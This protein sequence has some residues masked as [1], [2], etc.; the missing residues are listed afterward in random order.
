MMIRR[1]EL[2]HIMDEMCKELRVKFEED[3]SNC[4]ISNRVVGWQTQRPEDPN[5]DKMQLKP[6]DENGD[7]GRHQF[8]FR[9]INGL[10][11][12]FIKMRVESKYQEYQ[13]IEILY[14][15]AMTEGT[16]KVLRTRL[17][18]YDYFRP[19]VWRFL[20]FC[21]WARMIRIKNDSLAIESHLAKIVPDR[22][23]NI[24][25]GGNSAKS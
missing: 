8:G 9:T 1:P 6:T 21:E 23:D 22:V 2:F 25:L 10:K 3:F 17:F 4:L 5:D 24:L 13:N 12:G 20:R 7:D 11:I 19:S 18:W 16:N 14:L 15:A